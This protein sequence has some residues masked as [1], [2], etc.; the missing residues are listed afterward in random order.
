[1]SLFNLKMIN[2][3]CEKTLILL[4]ASV[5][6]YGWRCNTT[7]TLIQWIML[8]SLK[9]QYFSNA[10]YVLLILKYKIYTLFSIFN[11][12]YLK[13]WRY[14]ENLKVMAK[15]QYKCIVLL[16]IGIVKLWFFSW[17]KNKINCPWRVKWSFHG[18]HLSFY[19]C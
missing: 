13:K 9:L 3:S 8:M 11:F 18:V 10:N 4:E 7:I 14:Y 1:L 16:W 5:K 6:L 19:I 17:P 2:R 12:I 15:Q